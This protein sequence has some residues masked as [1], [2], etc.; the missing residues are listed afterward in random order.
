MSGKT[1]VLQ[2]DATQVAME[3]IYWMVVSS[4]Q[5]VVL[6]IMFYRI[7][8]TL[9]QIDNKSFLSKTSRKKFKTSQTFKMSKKKFRK[10]Q[11]QETMFSKFWMK[12]KSTTEQM[13]W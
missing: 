11:Y 3:W 12:G 1:N 9:F 4:S 13:P 6:S 7:M 5:L 2:M 10:Y 8:E